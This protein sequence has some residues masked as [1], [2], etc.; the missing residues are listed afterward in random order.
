MN[1]FDENDVT[2]E[3]TRLV[4]G[5]G[6]LRLIHRPSGLFVDADVKTGAVISTMNGLMND[7]RERVLSQVQPRGGEGVGDRSGGAAL[8]ALD[9]RGGNAAPLGVDYPS[10]RHPASEP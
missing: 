4:S 2:I 5:G 7:L 3:H 9:E 10:S 1:G 8:G 6:H